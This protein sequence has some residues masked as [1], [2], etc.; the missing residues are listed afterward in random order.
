M[1]FELF[2][3]NSYTPFSYF[4][5]SKVKKNYYIFNYSGERQ[6]RTRI[7]HNQS[8]VPQSTMQEGCKNAPSLLDVFKEHDE[9]K[10]FIVQTG[11]DRVDC[12][13]ITE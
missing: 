11:R 9:M 6:Q 5:F 12:D 2:K 7:S 10:F 1:F 13:K 8:K 4:F 3:K